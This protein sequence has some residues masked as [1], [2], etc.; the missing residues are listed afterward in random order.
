M[1]KTI[2]LCIMFLSMGILYFL[3]G[4]GLFAPGSAYADLKT[5][6]TLA[7]EPSPPDN[8]PLLLEKFKEIAEAKAKGDL[9]IR[10]FP[11]GSLGTQRQ[12][13]QQVQLGTT[14]AMGTASDMI[15]MEPKFSFVDFPFLFSGPE[16]VYRVLDG[17]IGQKLSQKLIREK[18]IRILCYGELGFRQITNRVRPI[19][20][21]DDLKGLKIRV[22]PVKLRVAAF[23]AMGAAATPIPYKELYTS[24]QQGVVDGQEN[25]VVTVKALSLWEVQKY[26][27][28]SN[29]VYT[30]AYLLINEKFWQS[31][32]LQMQNLLQESAI[33]ARDWNRR[34]SKNSEQRI[35]EMA[36]AKGMKV[37]NINSE[38][39]AKL[40]RPLWD[41]FADKVGRDILEKIIATR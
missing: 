36:K 22:P 1:R 30:P 12:I 5:V 41:Q 28:M 11:G 27:S 17:P 39:F 6:M 34:D 4:L 24:L 10:F 23:K 14:E 21:P 25:P 32:S 33:E 16:M 8:V 15:E 29:H 38:P 3:S 37:N 9:E 19:I 40:A 2:I 35:L 13:Q 31:L 26:I 7:C 18:G 20:H